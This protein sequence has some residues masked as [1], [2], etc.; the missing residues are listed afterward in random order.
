MFKEDIGRNRMKAMLV[1]GMPKSCA[2]CPYCGFEQFTHNPA[3]VICEGRF[4]KDEDIE[5]ERSAICPL[6]PLPK[7][8][9]R[10]DGEEF[11]EWE[12][13]DHYKNGYAN[14]WNDCLEEILGE[15]NG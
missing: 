12:C 1:I 15:D 7:T 6:R 10:I 11:R 4:G 5:N 8:K 13:E 14:G 3:C 2:D 9:E